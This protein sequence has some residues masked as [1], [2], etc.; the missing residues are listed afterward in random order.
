M[1]DVHNKMAYQNKGGRLPLEP[2][3]DCKNNK[4]L[5][6][7]ISEKEQVEPILQSLPID[8]SAITHETV[9]VQAQVT[10]TPEVFV[11]DIQSFCV[12]NP[13]I[14]SCSGLKSPKDAC[15]FIVSQNICVQ[16]PLTFS[17]SATA[18]LAGIVCGIPSVGPCP[19]S[20][21]CTHTIGYYRNHPSVT[22][23]LIAS[24][25]GAIILGEDSNG[26]SYT[27]TADN[28]YAVLTFNTPSP[29]AP[30]A[31]PF[32]QQYQQLYAQL[33]TAQLNV[34]SGAS[35]DHVIQ[36]ISAAN[37]F[38]STSPSGIGKEGAPEVQAPLEQFNSGAAPGC[39]G[40]C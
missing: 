27:V 6:H 21:G 5:D 23:S 15:S 3:C 20:T 37:S 31:Q 7:L 4:A 8:C 14:G 9:C 32:A 2:P 34:I 40:H 35:C 39:P 30:S 19:S 38:L 28:A 16:I 25:G 11:G 18:R 26:A 13:V 12:N 24:A 1:F 17:A 22:L 33:L 36:A 10:I 29:P